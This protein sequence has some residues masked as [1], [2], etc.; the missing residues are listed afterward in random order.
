MFL[1]TKTYQG[2]NHMTQVHF[3]LETEEIQ[4]LIENSVKDDTA[5]SILKMVFHQV[6]EQERTDYLQVDDYERSG[7]R[8]S[9]R[10]GYYERE[11]TTRVGTLDLKV[12]RT[13]DGK[14]SPDIFERYQRNE[15]AL[16]ASM[17]EMYVSGVSTR[18]VS[19][20]VEELC[21]KTVSKSFV[22]SLTKQ[23]DPLVSEWQNRILSDTKYPF[24]MV[25]VL[26]IKVRE[27][28]RVLSKSCHI[29]LGITEEGERE[30]IGFMIQNGESV[31]TWTTFFNYLKK[32]GLSGT[33]LV[34]SDAHPGLVTAIRQSFAGISWQR[35]QVH[36]MRNILETIPK[37]E[38]KP[39]RDSLKAIFRFTN[40]NLARAAK[41]QLLQAYEGKKKYQKACEKLDNGFEDAFQY[42]VMEQVHSRLKSTNLIERLNQEVRRREKTIRIFPNVASANRLV[43]AVLMDEHEEWISSPRKYIQF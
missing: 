10:N 8:V 15:K 3:T 28:H 2:G 42:T 21:G 27:D 12:P 11:L 32:R 40:I 29:A 33:Q 20:I 14:F 37:K 38:S 43:G 24:L 23:L 18:K 30:I 5:K 19:Q 34:I 1:T 31:E 22:S 16:L 9:Q 35:C 13:R 4:S 36:F 17:V 26:Y 39:F 6:M 41:D 25:D 7:N